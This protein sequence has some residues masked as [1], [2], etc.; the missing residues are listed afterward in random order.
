MLVPSKGQTVEPIDQRCIELPVSGNSQVVAELPI[1]YGKLFDA[2]F[3][4]PVEAFY[5]LRRLLP[6]LL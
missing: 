5:D 6:S 3:L 4:V 2:P 1:Q